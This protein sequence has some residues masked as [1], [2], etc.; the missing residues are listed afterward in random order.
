MSSHKD[1][2]DLIEITVYSPFL[3]KENQA[4]DHT[5]SSLDECHRVWGEQYSEYY[6][7]NIWIVKAE[8]VYISQKGHASG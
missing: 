8:K 3:I 2:S 6:K 4:L 5:F 7:Y 1:K